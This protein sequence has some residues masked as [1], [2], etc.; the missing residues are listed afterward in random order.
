DDYPNRLPLYVP[1]VALVFEDSEK[2]G[3]SD[4]DAWGEWRT[5]DSFP[6]ANG[7]VRLGPNGRPFGLSMFHQMH[8]LQMIRGAILAGGADYDYVHTKH[9]FNLIRQAILCASDTTLDPLDVTLDGKLAG[10][11]GL[12]Q[13]HVCRNWEKVYEFVYKNQLSEAWNMSSSSET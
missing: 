4:L 5:T 1:P 6:K 9:C 7:F 11:D 3:I 10:A 13:T 12:G 2:F 8:C